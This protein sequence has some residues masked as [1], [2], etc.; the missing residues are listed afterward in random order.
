MRI[1]ESETLGS[2]PVARRQIFH[3]HRL[4]ASSLLDDDRHLIEEPRVDSAHVV[5]GFDRH[6]A[7][8]QLTD[9]EDALRRGNG[10]A[11]QQ[12]VIGRR[13]VLLLG[14]IGV[15]TGTTLL[16]GAQSLLQTLGER[17]TDGHDLSDALHLRAENTRGA[18]QLL[19][20]PPRNLGDDVV[21]RGFETGRCHA[22]DVVRDLVEGVSDRQLGGD[23]GDRESGGFRRQCTR[24]G[25]AR[26]H[27]DDD[28]VAVARIDCELDVRSAGLDTDPTDAGEGRVT[29]AL[30]LDVAQRLG[31]GH[32]DRIARVHSHRIEVLDRADDHAVVGAI[33]HDL[34][35]VFLPAGDALLD[36]D[37]AD[38]TGV[39]TG[40]GQ[41]AELL[42]GGRDSRAT[43]TE[44]VRG[45]DDQGQ[46]DRRHDVH[47][48]VDR[49][50][51]TAS[52]NRETDFDHGL[53]EFLAILGGGDRFGVG[54]DQFGGSGS[55]DESALVQCHGEI[56]TGLPTERREDRIRT[57]AFDDARHD[58]P[59]EGLDVRAIREIGIGHDRRRIRIGEHDAVTLVL[60]H[61]A[62]LGPRIIEFTGLTDHDRPRSDDE[63][64]RE[65]G[66]SGHQNFPSVMSRAN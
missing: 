37:L 60:Q 6:A 14:R 9:L 17:A 13:V 63:D 25:H 33:T 29:H 61:A 19:E 30:I 38:R 10:D 56:E 65:I 27:L 49:V 35:F 22:S 41:T 47:G 45:T 16:E 55:P 12:F 46:T 32:R 36:E 18:G 28:L 64:G 1:A 66:T 11:S 31:R 50:G 43:T 54:A 58:L 3:R 44:D 34:E 39:E 20:S 48:L 21:D 24:S 42:G 59:R 57:F 26:V 15:Q 51:D 5:N 8:E 7:A 2:F 53:L 52:R 23:L 62:R 40:L 4:E